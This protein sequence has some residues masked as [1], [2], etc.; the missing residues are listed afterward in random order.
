MRFFFPSKGKSPYASSII[1]CLF[2]SETSLANSQETAS[3]DAKTFQKVVRLCV[4]CT[5]HT[6][7]MV[8]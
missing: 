3:V 8:A 2:Q 1:D 7:L 4:S 6:A 5:S